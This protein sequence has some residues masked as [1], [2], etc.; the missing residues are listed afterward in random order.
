VS[1]RQYKPHAVPQTPILGSVVKSID[2]SRRL[3]WRMALETGYDRGTG[4]QIGALAG[5]NATARPTP[6]DKIRLRKEP[7]GSSG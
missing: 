2:T 6:F 3:A 7:G 1:R 5:R 4:S